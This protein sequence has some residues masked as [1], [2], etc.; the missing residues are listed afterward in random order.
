MRIV[1]TQERFG[2]DDAA[3]DNV[4]LRLVV[5]RQMSPRHRLAQMRLQRQALA[6]C[7][8]HLFMEKAPCAAPTCLGAIHR[9][10]RALQQRLSAIGVARK[11]TNA[12]AGT[13]HH[14]KSIGRRPRHGHRSE[15]LTR[16]RSGT[17]RMAQVA[18]HHRHLIARHTPEQVARAQR[19]M[20]LQ[21]H[22]FEHCIAGCVAI[23]VVDVLEA[24]EVNLQHRQHLARSGRLLH[25]RVQ[26]LDKPRAVGQ[27]SQ[28]VVLR[29]HF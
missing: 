25:S 22:V 12:N 10:V 13:G 2:P 5:Q 28:R 29:Q 18:H 16:H 19:R 1:P 8:R 27:A 26:L 14:L 6:R 24:I 15:Q 11:H 4:H 21:R 17:L 23:A 20:H 7:L 3:S 9:S